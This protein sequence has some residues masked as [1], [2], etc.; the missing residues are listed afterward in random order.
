MLPWLLSLSPG[1]IFQPGAPDG[2]IVP[3]PPNQDTV[4]TLFDAGVKSE[5]DMEAWLNERRV[6]NE[7][8]ACACAWEGGWGVHVHVSVERM[9]IFLFLSLSLMVMMTIAM[10]MTMTI[11]AL[12]IVMMMMMM[13]MVTVPVA[14][15]PAWLLSG[16]EER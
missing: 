9:S 7:V 1:R 5:E 16:A 14:A 11:M 8:C 12:M 10:T 15:A 13:V 2:K 6:V 4:N 3:I